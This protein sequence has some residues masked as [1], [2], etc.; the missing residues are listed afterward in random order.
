VARCADGCGRNVA[1]TEETTMKYIIEIYSRRN[2]K[3][4][5]SVSYDTRADAA[6]ALEAYRKQYPAKY[7]GFDCMCAVTV[8]YTR[9]DFE[10]FDKTPDAVFEQ[11]WH[12]ATKQ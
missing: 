2:D 5:L 12:D 7:F 4:V 11:L 10:T 9:L 6:E 1:V 8:R 3:A